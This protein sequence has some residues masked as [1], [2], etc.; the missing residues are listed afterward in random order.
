MIY[1][2]LALLN[3]S[4]LNLKMS[5]VKLLLNIIHSIISLAS[6][7]NLVGITF[8]PFE[9]TF[10]SCALLVERLLPLLLLVNDFVNKLT[11]YEI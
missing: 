3:N 5:N 6:T 11:L 8:V 2:S 9:L 7:F 10:N 1:L 4:S